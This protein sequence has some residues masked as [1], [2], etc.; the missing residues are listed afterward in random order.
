MTKVRDGKIGGDPVVGEATMVQI[1]IT[2]TTIVISTPGNLDPIGVAMGGFILVTTQEIGPTSLSLQ[3]TLVGG[4]EEVD[5]N[6]DQV[7]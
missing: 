6:F 4:S 7:I 3:E 1:E 5:S 2:N